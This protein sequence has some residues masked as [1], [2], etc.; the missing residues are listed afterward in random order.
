MAARF[1]VHGTATLRARKLF[2]LTGEI[3]S[4]MVRTGMRASLEDSAEEFS[5]R[6][7]GVEHLETGDDGAGPELAVLFSYARRETLEAWCSVDWEGRA[8]TLH[9]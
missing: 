5:E 6:V 9:W 3:R 1:D 4:G 8:L 2:A 7:H